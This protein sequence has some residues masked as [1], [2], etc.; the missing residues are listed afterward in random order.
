MVHSF[1]YAAK[2]D[3]GLVRRNNQDAFH[4]SLEHG[5]V[6]VADGMGGHQA[7]EI[8]S[9][10]AIEGIKNDLEQ[11]RH[12]VLIQESYR[13]P[14]IKNNNKEESSPVIDE[15]IEI[16]KQLEMEKPVEFENEPPLTMFD[17]I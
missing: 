10:V 12:S 7:G 16:V 11:P 4:V 13:S 9:Q 5:V 3:K 8:A 2:S 15:K 14:L 6:V 17:H 1:A